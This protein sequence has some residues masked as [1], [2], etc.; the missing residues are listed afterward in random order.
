MGASGD[1]GGVTQLTNHPADDLSPDWQPNAEGADNGDQG[2]GGGGEAKTQSSAGTI[3]G[4]SIAV[5]H[6]ALAPIP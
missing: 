6:G 2:S 3:G 5:E 4:Q 1:S